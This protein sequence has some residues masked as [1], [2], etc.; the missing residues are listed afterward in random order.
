MK[1]KS[2]FQQGTVLEDSDKRD[3]LVK[4]RFRLWWEP[5]F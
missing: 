1:S 3:A 2:V 4:E 5:D